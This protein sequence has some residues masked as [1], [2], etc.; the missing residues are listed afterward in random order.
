MEPSRILSDPD[1]QRSDALEV[2]HSTPVFKFNIV[3]SYLHVSIYIN[4]FVDQ[5]HGMQ[6]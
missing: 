1:L 6:L 3:Y 2:D 4:L 5:I